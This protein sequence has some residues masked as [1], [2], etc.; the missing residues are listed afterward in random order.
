MFL[1]G[2]KDIAKYLGRGVR[3]VQRW[4]ALGLPIRRPV[5]HSRSA[6][7]AKSEEIDLWI[8]RA[9]TTAER[10]QAT[11]QDL[12]NIESTFR[13][14]LD[15]HRH[16]VKEQG[17]LIKELRQARQKSAEIRESVT[18]LQVSLHMDRLLP[19]GRKPKAG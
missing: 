6:V 12:A 18:K 13:L 3:T 7:V 9:Q 10:L 2:W 16:L 14:A 11:T 1:N 15:Y 8:S 4:E 5:G 19:R 17:L